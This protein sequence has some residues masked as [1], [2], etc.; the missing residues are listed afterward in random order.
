MG[1]VPSP[2]DCSLVNR[3]LKTLEVR[4]QQHMK[5]GIAVAKFLENHPFVSKV[6]HPCKLEFYKSNYSF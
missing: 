4:M 1:I 6:I 2:Y 5:N 3:S